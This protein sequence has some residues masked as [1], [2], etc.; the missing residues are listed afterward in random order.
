MAAAKHPDHHASRDFVQFGNPL[1]NPGSLSLHDHPR[2]AAQGRAGSARPRAR[3]LL[4]ENLERLE[5]LSQQVRVPQQ[6]GA[7]LRSETATIKAW[8]TRQRCG[9]RTLINENPDDGDKRHT[10][11]EF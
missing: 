4:E 8:R 5:Q 3:M 7:G 2:S 9:L 11:N 1:G 6:H 10:E